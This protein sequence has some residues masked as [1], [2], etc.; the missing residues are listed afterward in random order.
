[1][2][3]IDIF[4]DGYNIEDADS[5]PNEVTRECGCV[6]E[7]LTT[8]T[9]IS[10]GLKTQCTTHDTEDTNQ[11]EQWKTD[12]ITSLQKI[13]VTLSVE[14]DKATDLGYTAVASDLQSQIDTHQAEIEQL[15]SSGE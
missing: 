6:Y 8:S 2:A 9:G 14:K 12:R 4:G 1:M 5:L 15:Q 10:Y 3:N 13:I 11:Y 7:K